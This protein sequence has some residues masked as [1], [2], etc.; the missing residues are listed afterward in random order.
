[1]SGTSTT[2]AALAL[3][4]AGVAALSLAMDRHCEHMMRG[5]EPSHGRRIAARA[6]GALLL[7]SALWCNTVAWGPSVGLVAWCGWIAAGALL[8][9]MV[10]T[11]RPRWT[12]RAGLAAAALAAMAL[13]LAKR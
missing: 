10:L 2:L 8:V 6:A 9:T 12:G 11:W 3:C 1:M 13:T 7:A 4:F 5:G